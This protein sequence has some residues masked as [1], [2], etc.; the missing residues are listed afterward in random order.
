MDRL[1]KWFMIFLLD[2]SS[3]TLK[4]IRSEMLCFYLWLMHLMTKWS[5]IFFLP[6]KDNNN[7][8][9]D[10]LTLF[11]RTFLMYLFSSYYITKDKYSK[12]SLNK[13]II[14]SMVSLYSTYVA[15]DN[16]TKCALNPFSWSIGNE[17]Y[18]FIQVCVMNRVPLLEKVNPIEVIWVW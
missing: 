17:C 10:W 18:T 3:W 11:A 12:Y 14:R 8:A 7:C 9:I 6:L 2:F 5:S 13:I 16:K 15:K 4:C 1:L